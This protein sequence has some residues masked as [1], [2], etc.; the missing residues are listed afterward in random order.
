MRLEKGL[1]AVGD[2]L[3]QVFAFFG[4]LAMREVR[5]ER[6]TQGHTEKQICRFFNVLDM[7]M[8]GL[9]LFGQPLLNGEGPSGKMKQVCHDL[10]YGRISRG[11]RDDGL[12]KA[13]ALFI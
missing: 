11:F 4:R 5:Q 2:E 7:E 10:S 13:K 6:A 8:A 9:G 3:D 1:Y 12:Q